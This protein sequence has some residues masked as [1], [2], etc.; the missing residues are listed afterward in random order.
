[1][2]ALPR[3]FIASGAD[4]VATQSV[5]KATPVFGFYNRINNTKPAKYVSVSDMLGLASCPTVELKDDA[6]ALTPFKAEGKTK[7]HAQ[8][9]AFHAIVKDH[10]DDD[11]TA[12]QIRELYDAPGFAY[13]AFTSASHQQDKHGVTANRWKVV[14]PLC[15]GVDHDRYVQVS[16]GA[17]LLIGTDVVQSRGTQVFYAPNIIAEGAPYEFIDATDRPF[18]D[19]S[20]DTDPFIESCL[21]EYQ[22]AQER[23]R[24]AAEQAT[25]APRAISSEDGKIIDKVNQ[26]GNLAQDIEAR[27]YRRIGKSWLSPQSSTGTPGVHIFT[28]QDGKDRLYSHHGESDPLSA[29]H[30]PNAKQPGRYHALDRF[31]VICVLDYSGDVSRAVAAEAKVADPEGQKQR[32]IAH[33]KAKAAK[34]AQADCEALLKDQPAS[35]SDPGDVDLLSPPGIAGDICEY[36]NATARRPRPELSPFAALQLLALIARNRRSVYTTKLNMIT[37][38]IAPTAAGKEHPQEVAKRLARQ[39]FCSRYIHGNAGSFKDLIYNLLEGDGAC[40]YVVDEVHSLLGSMKDKN[41]QTYESKMEAEILTMNSTELYTFRGM[42]KRQLSSI[43]AQ[44]LKRLKKAAEF[45]DSEAL[46]RLERAIRKIKSRIEWL[47]HG[48]PNPFF[49]LMGHSVPERL[50]E[51]IKPD[52]ISSGFLGRTLIMRC[53]ETREKLRRKPVDGAH[54]GMLAASIVQGLKRIGRDG[55]IVAPDTEAG[56]YLERAVDW[57]DDDEQL[58]HPIVGGIYARAPEH[59]YRIASILAL[60]GGTITIEHAKYAH[61]LV[62]QSVDDVKHILLKFYADSESATDAQVLEHARQVVHRNCKGSGKQASILRQLITKPKGWQERQ[63]KDETRDYFAE[64]IEWM[65]SKGELEKVTSGRK[66]RYVSQIRV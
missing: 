7:L 63:S 22:K 12:D 51:F 46:P 40:L 54:T 31:A 24:K 6:A 41:A 29:L 33:E 36:M 23:Q 53:P 28:G 47:E 35:E 4:V 17:D 5:S 50:D 3:T 25:P 49:S 60:A 34:H 65:V 21:A 45:A 16:R 27:G 18:L 20:D 43:Y 37:L 10:D 8:E 61:A 57:Y 1:M 48:M 42:E 62:R 55:D 64:F 44:E 13:L 56:E 2:S 66:E 26:S 59:L 14:I 11:R 38:A 52:N 30:F 15:N 39:V 9:A 58:N 32:Q 19:A